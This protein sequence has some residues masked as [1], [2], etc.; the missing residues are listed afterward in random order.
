M[1]VT[2]DDNL[3][4]TAREADAGLVIIERDEAK[5]SCCAA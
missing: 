2:P 4:I 3:A 1:S 5:R